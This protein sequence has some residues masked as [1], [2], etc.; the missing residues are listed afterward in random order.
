MRALVKDCREF[1]YVDIDAKL[2]LDGAGNLDISADKK[3]KFEVDYQG[4][5]L[6]LQAGGYVG[7]VPVNDRL[8]L[9]IAPRVPLAN[10]TQIVSRSGHRPVQLEMLR[11][12]NQDDTIEDWLFDTYA[13]FLERSIGDLLDQGLYR[14]YQRRDESG[15]APHGS[16]NIAGTVRHFAA[17]NVAFKADYSWFERTLDNPANQLI[18]TALHVLLHYYERSRIE[19]T[20]R[21]DVQRIRRLATLLAPFDDVST[22][23]A[24]LLLSDPV[25]SGQR[26]LPDA[27]HYYRDVLDAAANLVGERGV[28]FEQG[29]EDL[30]LASLLIDMKEVFERYVRILLQDA[31]TEAG[32]DCVVQDG[33]AEGKRRLYGEPTL[34]QQGSWGRGLARRTGVGPD[35]TPDIVMLD[36]DGATPLICEVKYTKPKK[37]PERSEVEQAVTYALT[38]DTGRVLLIHPAGNSDAGLHFVGRVGSVEVFDFRFDLGAADLL[39]EADAYVNS[40]ARLLPQGMSGV[41]INGTRSTPTAS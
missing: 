2:L 7:I 8:A 26:A 21:G 15:S 35:A 5:R 37:L 13:D 25:V 33:N 18:K 39:V 9:R 3:D 40:V 34:A 20:R 17:R 38:H 6:R 16:I 10:L 22:P 36:S 24:R 4:G 1:S 14:T 31:A 32:W 23:D 41:S 29:L 11:A 12:Y 19:S 27:R 28:K 30:R